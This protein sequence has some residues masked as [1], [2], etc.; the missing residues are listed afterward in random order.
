MAKLEVNKGL[1]LGLVG[2]AAVSLLGLVFMLG[3][4][5]AK[6]RPVAAQPSIPESPKPVSPSPEPPSS[7][8]PPPVGD[9]QGPVPD[10]HP[11]ALV[12]AAPAPVL[13]MPAPA[14]TAESESVRQGVIQYFRALDALQPSGA[15]GNSETMARDIVGSLMKGDASG[16]DDLTRQA[17]ATRDRMGAITPPTPCVAHYRES[18]ALLN[19]ELT[20]MDSLKQAMEGANA[21]NL[22]A[23]LTQKG[24]ALRARSEALQAHEQAL[25]ARYG[26]R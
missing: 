19:E 25:R 7:L 16:F 26:V 22:A 11:P 18:M 6:P 2:V 5:S 8:P 4:E 23:E 3:R 10:L 12:Q 17:K 20:M 14:P 1:L 13:A 21:S 9:S 24:N 15:G